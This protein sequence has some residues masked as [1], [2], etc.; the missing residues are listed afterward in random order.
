M[1]QQTTRREIEEPRLLGRLGVP[2]AVTRG[3]ATLHWALLRARP[4]RRLRVLFIL[5]HQRSG[6]TLLVHCLNTNPA[7][8]GCGETLLHYETEADLRRLPLTVMVQSRRLV[9]AQE[10]L[11]DK[12]LYDELLGDATL[13][14][15]PRVFALFLVRSAAESLASL[16]RAPSL[17]G[18]PQRPEANREFVDQDLCER[19][20]SGRLRTLEEYARTIGDKGRS[21]FIT[22]DDLLNRTPRLFETL[23]RFLDLRGSFSEQYERIRTTGRAGFGDV[24]ANIQRGRLSREIARPACDVRPDLLA[25]ASSAF[26]QCRSSLAQQCSV[27]E[28]SE[29][30]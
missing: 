8:L 18:W 23:A 15:S 26:E 5:S 21:L 10:Y 29:P 16:I 4:G 28:P 19:Y 9:A 13:L 12:L 3:L 14:R 27:L 25:R 24:S 1:T 17:E 30:H 22:Y 11:S 20:Y 6:S 2:P 7:V